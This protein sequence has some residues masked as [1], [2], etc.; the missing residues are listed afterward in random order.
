MNE[1]EKKEVFVDNLFFIATKRIYEMIIERKKITD[2]FEIFKIG[3]D[4]GINP[5]NLDFHFQDFSE[6]KEDE[7]Q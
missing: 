7:K 5:Y 1:R 3:I 6:S 2:P 4:L